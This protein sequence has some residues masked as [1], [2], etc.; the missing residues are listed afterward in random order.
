MNRLVCVLLLACLGWPAAAQQ[1]AYPI[2][3]DDGT[4]V[5]NHRV[6]AAAADEVEGLPGAVI[7]GN[8]QGDVTLAE[9][10][11]L[12]CPYC[13]KASADMA[14]LLKEDAK[15]RLVLV[16]FPV[17][18]IPSI[19]AGRVELAVARLGT[20]EQFWQFHRRIF[21][22]RGVVDGERALAV[23]RDLG[24]ANEKLV[25]VAND[26]AVTETMKAHVRLGNTLG[27]QATPAYV[28]AG[29]A[30]VGHPGRKALQAIVA[31]VRRCRAVVC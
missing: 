8:P 6:P 15:L 30:I 12:N 1:A 10:Y 18:G 13:R 7:L 9:F 22:G 14:A 2:K 28:V 31:A 3:A 26:N 27:L 25:A 21:S 20:P 23:A 24:F 17:L 16:P 4:I 11:D 5:A 29:V 19:L